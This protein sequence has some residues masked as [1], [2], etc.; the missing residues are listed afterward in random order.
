MNIGYVTAT[1]LIAISGFLFSC[2]SNTPNE[3]YRTTD[4]EIKANSFLLYVDATSKLVSSNHG[5]SGDITSMISLPAWYNK[6]NEISVIATTG[7]TYVF[8]KRTPAL[9]SVLAKKTNKSYSLGVADNN[10]ITL[11]SITIPKPSLIPNNSIV[12]VISE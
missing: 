7:R 12:Y 10:V 4:V 3:T 6:N 1:F 2:L 11:P 8:T 9:L 5:A